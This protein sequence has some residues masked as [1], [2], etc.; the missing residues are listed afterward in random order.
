MHFLRTLRHLFDGKRDLTP[1]FTRQ[2]EL[3]CQSSD[4]LVRMLAT[5]D[6]TQWNMLQ[7]EIKSCETQ[8]DALLQ[9]FR[10]QLSERVMGSLSRTDLST[11]A[12][13]MD[14][15]LDVIKDAAKAV[16][17]AVVLEEVAKMAIFT[18]Q[19]NPNALPAPQRIQDKHYMRKHGP[20]AYYGQGKG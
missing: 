3:L 7:R 18:R 12:M 13:S 5:V 15:S 6:P 11:I 1:F 14:D 17:H 19:V 10:E 2:A 20:N 8:G 4:T 16:Y 9:D